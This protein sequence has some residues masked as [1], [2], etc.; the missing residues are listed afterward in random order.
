MSLSH[1]DRTKIKIALA[2]SKNASQ[3]AESLGLSEA[4]VNIFLTGYRRTIAAP[5]E[6][7]VRPY[8]RRDNQ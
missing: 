7:A 1:T 5:P 2:S 3:I 4:A 6:G 8:R